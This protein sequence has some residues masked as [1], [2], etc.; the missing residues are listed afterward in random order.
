MVLK[1]SRRS[2]VD[3]F[4][5]RIFEQNFDAA[6]PR[7]N[8]QFFKRRKGGFD[9]VLGKLLSVDAQML[10]QILERNDFRDLQRALDLIHPPDAVGFFAFRNVDVRVR[11]GAAPDLVGIHGRMQRVQLQRGIAEPVPEFSDL[12][13]VAVIEMLRRTEDLDGRD[14]GASPPGSARPWSGDG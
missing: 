13:F 6:L 14:P 7:E 10:N 2:A 8:H 11:P 9:G 1:S 12:R 4:V 3:K 5:R